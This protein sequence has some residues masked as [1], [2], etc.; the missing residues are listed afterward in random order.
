MSDVSLDGESGETAVI[1]GLVSSKNE[2]YTKS[3]NSTLW[4]VLGTVGTVLL[5]LTIV[6]VCSKRARYKVGR[7]FSEMFAGI[8]GKRKV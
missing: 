8:F 5:T 7:F 4:V 1:N 6:L 2:T 3:S